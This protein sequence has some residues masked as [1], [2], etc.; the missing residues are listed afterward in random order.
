[1][2]AT[3]KQVATLA[4]EIANGSDG[5]TRKAA[6]VASVA[7]AITSSVANAR[8]ALADLWHTTWG[9]PRSRSISWWWQCARRFTSAC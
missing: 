6:N 3:N 2:T 7:L 1:M 8:N 9:T 4:A 5:M